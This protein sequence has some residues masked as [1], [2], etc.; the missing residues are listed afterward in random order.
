MSYI[1]LDV[2]FIIPPLARAHAIVSYVN[3][4][5]INFQMVEWYAGDRVLRQFGCC[6]HILDISI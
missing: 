6:Q 1:T 3:A 2:V 4:P 5:I